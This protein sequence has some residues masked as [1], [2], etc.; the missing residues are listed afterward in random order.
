MEDQRKDK[1]NRPV[2]LRLFTRSSIS[3][4]GAHKELHSETDHITAE[5]AADKSNT[6]FVINGINLQNTRDLKGSG[7]FHPDERKTARN[8]EE[9]W[10]WTIKSGEVEPRIEKKRGVP[11]KRIAKSGKELPMF[12]ATIIRINPTGPGRDSSRGSQA[13]STKERLVTS[14]KV[15]VSITDQFGESTRFEGTVGT[16]TDNGLNSS[17]PRFAQA[18]FGAPTFGNSKTPLPSF[19]KRGSGGITTNCSSTD[20]LET[21]ASTL[22]NLSKAPIHERDSLGK[23]NGSTLKSERIQLTRQA[24][25]GIAK[26]DGAD[27]GISLSGR[28]G[29][30]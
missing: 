28:N 1:G 17:A 9:K 19:R 7:D 16:L 8:E 4:R 10:N 6:A 14:S 11:P 26:V 25:K 5:G 22:V 12:S 15:A 18:E 2:K 21:A 24:M 3:S 23:A 27:R 13:V 20:A 30:R 29:R